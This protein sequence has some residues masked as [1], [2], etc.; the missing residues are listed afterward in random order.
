MNQFYYNLLGGSIDR[1]CS[2][3]LKDVGVLTFDLTDLDRPF[4]EQEFWETVK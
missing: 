2:I 3:N 4:L 1:D